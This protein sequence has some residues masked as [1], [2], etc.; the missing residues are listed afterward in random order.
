VSSVGPLFALKLALVPLFLGLLSL[1]GRRWGPRVAGWLAG[2]P[3]VTAPILYFVALER[4][5]DFAAQAARATLAAVFAMLAFNLSFAWAA[6]RGRWPLAFGAGLI[7]WFVAALVVAALPP[8]LA[9]CAVVALAA[10]RAAP[11]LFPAPPEPHAVHA[12]PAYE[13]LLRMAAGALFV[14]A[15]TASAAALGAGWT[16]RL[17]T[18]PI[19]GL[20]LA[21]FTHRASGG[22]AAAALLRAMARGLYS[23]ATFCFMVAL[24][25]PHSGLAIA[26]GAAIV[27]GLVVQAASSRLL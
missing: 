22:A 14:V 7:G 12:P 1:A 13:L 4:G 23:Y 2:L 6:Q 25:L 3:L 8:S 16:G 18:I 10:L 15:V 9:V 17:S 26:F 19:L 11:R 5:H 27:V 24:L 20:V 21:I